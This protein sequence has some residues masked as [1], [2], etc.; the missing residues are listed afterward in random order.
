L[1]C[2]ILV[3]IAKEVKMETLVIEGRVLKKLSKKVKEEYMSLA[4][5]ESWCPYFEGQRFIII[6]DK[7]NT[8]NL[9]VGQRK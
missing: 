6:A 8:S 7:D 9:Y 1:K 5:G 4:P 2:D 3:R